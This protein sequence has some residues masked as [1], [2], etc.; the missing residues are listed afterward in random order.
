MT[1]SPGR[2]DR[3]IA[4]LNPV[5][6]RVSPSYTGAG[7]E[8]DVIIVGSGIGGG[9][10]A[11]AIADRKDGLRI[12]LLE[13]G[14]FL[15]PTHVYNCARLPNADVAA[16]FGCGTFKQQAESGE[17]D[18][19]FFIGERPQMN[20]GGRSIF[21]SGL[22]PTLQ[23]WE[24]D[25]FPPS[26]RA[27]LNDGLLDEAGR[28]MNE[29]V[30]LG[31]AA[32]AIVTHLRASLLFADFEIVQTPR[33]LHQPYLQAG[34]EA[35]KDFT[36]DPTGVF[37]TAELLV[38]QV[39]LAREEPGGDPKGLN[40]LLNSYVEDVRRVPDGRLEVVSRNT[41]TGEARMF[42]AAR[43]VIAGGSIESPKLL[44]RSTI[45][46]TLD[47]AV[48]DLIGVGLTDHP[49]TD[50]IRGQATRIGDFEIPRGA[51]A[52][53]IFYSRGR[54]GDDGLIR[55]PFNI[56]MNVNHE[57]WHLRETDPSSPGA[58]F[59]ADG[60]PSLEIKFSFGNPLDPDNV[61][62]PAAPFDY[63]PEIRFR[64]QKHT[65]HLC[66]QRFPALAGWWKTDREVFDLLNDLA[67][68][69]FGEFTDGNAQAAPR[70][71]LG[72]GGKGFGWGTVHH[73][74]GSLRMPSKARHDGEF[75][76]GVVTEDLE[77]RGEAG[78]GLYVCDMSVMPF[79]AAANPVRH[80]VALALRLAER[81]V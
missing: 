68:R 7:S 2:Y 24:L 51:S 66:G 28:K 31:D 39:G 65:G 19:S 15:Y 3:F 57:Y 63:V 45:G 41:L 72:E 26:V 13:A 12:L 61:I 6:E 11:D 4:D 23:A 79:S 42:Q 37:N 8:F 73:A 55:Y 16:R 44:R 49:T 35:A 78:R 58:P 5:F 59:P 48:Q 76:P 10:L 40:I 14:T 62:H 70:D 34:G 81:I 64:N 52:K 29:S 69:V 18:N 77:V 9:V 80:L 60:P 54:R 1:F 30:T 25:F 27:A 75:S 38:N 71:K 50:V 53:V 67:R 46:R 74:V 47:Q 36:L 43:V 22:I 32:E 17:G 20:L 33:A 56:E 21:W